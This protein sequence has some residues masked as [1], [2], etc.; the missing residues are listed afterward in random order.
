[1]TL[2]RHQ[3]YSKLRGAIRNGEDSLSLINHLANYS[4]VKNVYA[5]RLTKMIKNNNLQ[6][7]D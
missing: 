5:K 2:S 4:E 7:H 3:S 1:M 6:K